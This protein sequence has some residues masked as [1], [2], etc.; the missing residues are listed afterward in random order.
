MQVRGI[1]HHIATSGVTV[2]LGGCVLVR[3]RSEGVRLK[4]RVTVGFGA[5]ILISFVFCVV[6][7]AESIAMVSGSSTVTVWMIFYL[8]TTAMWSAWRWR[9]FRAWYSLD[10][11]PFGTMFE[12]A[13]KEERMRLSGT[14][15]QY[16]VHGQVTKDGSLR[17]REDG[18]MEECMLRG[19]GRGG[20]EGRE[21]GGGIG[22]GGG[23]EAEAEKRVA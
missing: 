14:V 6:G 11:D 21:G 10:D 22:G 3:R 20:R 12:E 4:M 1:V 8:S 18:R 9:G 2:K 23:G 5:L 13:C 17:R 16:T 19:K 7:E 15:R